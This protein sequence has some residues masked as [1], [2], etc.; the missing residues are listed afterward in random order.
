MLIYHS[1]FKCEIQQ[2]QNTVMKITEIDFRDDHILLS[3]II[4]SKVNVK[5]Y[6]DQIG[7]NHF[8]T[9][10]S[11]VNYNSLPV[12]DVMDLLNTISDIINNAKCSEIVRM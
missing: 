2:P 9:I 10:I 3:C 8:Q 7:I 1:I 5:F 4:D 11:F 12:D 6:I